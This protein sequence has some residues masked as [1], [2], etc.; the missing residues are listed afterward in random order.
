MAYHA[1]IHPLLPH[2]PPVQQQQSSLAAHLIHHDPSSL[3]CPEGMNGAC[4]ITHL[5]GASPGLYM[6][7][8]ESWP[9]QLVHTLKA[10]ISLEYLVWRN[11]N[12]LTRDLPTSSVFLCLE[13]STKNSDQ[14][15]IPFHGDVCKET[16]RLS[17]P[18]PGDVNVGFPSTEGQTLSAFALEGLKGHVQDKSSLS[19]MMA[20]VDASA[21]LYAICKLQAF[22]LGHAQSGK[23][24]ELQTLM[25]KLV[26]LANAPVYAHFIFDGEDHR[27]ASRFTWSMA[28]GE[29]D[30]NLAFLSKV[31]KISAVLMEDSDALLFGAKKVLCI[32][33]NE[34][35]TF[36]VD[37][38]CAEALSNDPKIPLTTFHLLL[39]A[40]LRR[41]D[42][43]P[44]HGVHVCQ[45][46]FASTV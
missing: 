14:L 43:N 46:I 11:F 12:H 31:G 34:D 32:V 35:G 21:W 26:T 23:N 15:S 36:L 7:T 30:A 8:R 33:D 24:P 10:S 22:Q 3:S 17:I 13:T 18:F 40:M 16:D 45:F 41:G 37:T 38:Y 25:Y 39:W 20:G 28:K 27:A 19:M 44:V 9:F 1:A 29:A 2:S 4:S 6:L 5:I 42:Y